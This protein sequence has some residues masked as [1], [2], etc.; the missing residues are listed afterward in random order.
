MK[1]A[2]EHYKFMERLSKGIIADDLSDQELEI[3]QFL[4]N[5]GIAAPKAHI[6]DGLWLLSPRGQ[7]IFQSAQPK[8]KHQQY[9]GDK[10]KKRKVNWVSVFNALIS[11]I[12]V[13]AS[14]VAILEF[15]FGIMG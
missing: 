1:Y 7:A 8:V 14:I 15:L 10:L 3:L 6:Q 11:I 9:P 12:G 5:E 2:K 13:A 4:D